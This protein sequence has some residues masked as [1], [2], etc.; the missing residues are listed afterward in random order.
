MAEGR[1]N[2]PQLARKAIL[3]GANAVTVGSAIT[4]I[5]NI[6]NWFVKEITR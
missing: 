1:Y 3:A 4:R 6:T 2:T 5:E